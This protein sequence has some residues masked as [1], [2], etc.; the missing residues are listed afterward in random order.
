M[1]IF[2]ILKGVKQS[3][4]K[5]M[6][7]RKKF[8]MVQANYISD[9]SPSDPTSLVPSLPK[10]SSSTRFRSSVGVALGV[11]SVG[12]DLFFITWASFLISGPLLWI[13]PLGFLTRQI[14]PAP[15]HF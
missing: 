8:A 2:R 13:H 12:V 6:R 9:V 10:Y 7:C 11:V 5:I 14:L 3:F 4:L 1:K 15:Y